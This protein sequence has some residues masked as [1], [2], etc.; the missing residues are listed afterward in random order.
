MGLEIEERKRGLLT[1]KLI[2]QSLNK[3]L[4]KSVLEVGLEFCHIV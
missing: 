3:R 4:L 2:D 1:D